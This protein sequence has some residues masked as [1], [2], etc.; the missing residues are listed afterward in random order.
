MTLCGWVSGEVPEGL[1]FHAS[2]DHLTTDADVAG[3]SGSCS[4]DANLDF[5]PAAGIRESGLLQQPGER[6]TY[7]VPGNLDTS[8]GSFSVWVKPLNWN[9]HSGKFH[10]FLTVTGVENYRMLLYLYPIGDEAVLNYIRVNAGT[11]EDRTYRAGAGVDFLRENEWTHLVST[12]DRRDVRLYANGKRVGEG[13]VSSPLPKA[14]DG[15]FTICP[16]SFW[17]HAQWSDDN[18]QTVCDEVRIFDRALSDEDVLALYAHDLPGGMP[19]LKPVL[20]LSV[21]PDY[22]D[23]RLSVDV[24]T[25]H[26]DERWQAAVDRGLEAAIRVTDPSGNV[27]SAGKHPLPA[28]ELSVPVRA[29]QEGDYVIE[30]EVAADGRS[31][32]AAARVTKPPTPWLPRETEWRATRVLAPWSPLVHTERG[33]DYWNGSVTFAGALPATVTSSGKNVLARPISLV[34]DSASAVV[35]EPPELTETTGHRVTFSTDGRLGPCRLSGTTLIEFDGL[36]RADVTVTPP[37]EDFELNRLVLEIP[38]AASVATWYR[39]PT[40]ADWDG[41]AHDEPRFLP[42]GWLG[43][44]TCGLSWFMESDANW[45]VPHGHPH[46]TL[47]P[48]DG[49][50]VVRLHLIAEPTVLPGPVSYTFGFEAT[51]VRPMPEDL[52]TVRWAGGPQVENVNTFVY[53]W[54]HQISPLNG[55]LIAHDPDDQRRLVDRWRRNGCETRSYTCTQCT[56]NISPEYLFFGAEWHQP[57]GASFSGYKRVGDDAPYSM[58]PVC[59]RSSFADFLVWCVREHVRNDW[60]GGIYTDIDG[61][62]PCDNARH[63]CGYVDAFGRRGRTW[64]LYAHRGLS[65]RIYEACHD[66]GK[67][68]FSHAHSNWYSVYNAFN[69]GW[70]PGEQYSSAVMKDPYFYMTSMPDRVWRSEFCTRPTGVRTFLLPQL[71]RLGDKGVKEE[72]GPSESCIAAAMAYG[73]PLWASCNRSVVEEV[74]RVQKDFGMDGV[75]FVPFWS[76]DA[77][78]CDDPDLRISYWEKDGRRLIVVALL[79]PSA[80]RAPAAFT[81]AWVPVGRCEPRAGG[82]AVTVPGL[83]GILVTAEPADG[84]RSADKE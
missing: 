61:T 36:I 16:I 25:A 9:G 13:R 27:L 22:F 21:R 44:G 64:P 23:R 58:V 50:V 46:V 84:G 10:H 28:A 78:A 1:L 38:I 32:A 57:Y 55:R 31:L 2:F 7:E 68:Y 74:W 66:A 60:G 59:P 4:L 73:V 45:R 15:T 12:W 48:V 18:E 8:Q 43:N 30:A 20:S 72:R 11:D 62:K 54:R 51:P 40:C 69:D 3:G 63:G 75:R 24:R 6:C 5:R 83:R 76:Q 77:Y 14:E 67:E 65:R 79:T 39:N 17:N 29:W 80:G 19:D 37:A 42:Y 70:A 47:R 35:W 52:Y 49:A 82:I 26:L 56:A 53:G 41:G 34:S 71:G 33:V 81:P